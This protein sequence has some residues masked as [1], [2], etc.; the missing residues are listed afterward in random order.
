[1]GR[2]DLMV[3]GST[4]EQ[5]VRVRALAGDIVL[6]SLSSVCTYAW[7]GDRRYSS[8][9]ALSNVRCLSLRQGHRS[10]FPTNNKTR[11]F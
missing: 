2:G 5:A 6:S 9:R 11:F 4:P 1:M 10:H 8:Q 3:S 7:N